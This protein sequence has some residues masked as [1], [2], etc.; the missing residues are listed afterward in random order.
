MAFGDQRAFRHDRRRPRDGIGEIE[1]V[2]CA[3]ERGFRIALE[4]YPSDAHAQNGL[5]TA[6]GP[7]TQARLATLAAT[8]AVHPFFPEG[9]NVELATVEN[10]GH[11]RILIWERGVGPTEASGTGACAAAFDLLQQTLLQLAVPEEQRGRAVGIWVLGI[12]SAP[13]GH[14]EMGTL[15]AAFGAPVALVV[16]GCCVLAGAAVLLVRAPTYRWFP[17]PAAA[18]VRSA[19][20]SPRA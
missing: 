6:L 14:L 17:R 3:A 7:A 12:G 10:P 8:L 13:V 19:E 9:T 18:I 15:V 4:Q 11:V 5:R 20:P 16:N 2:E 1:V